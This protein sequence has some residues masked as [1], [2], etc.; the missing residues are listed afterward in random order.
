MKVQV[1]ACLGSWEHTFDIHVGDGNKTFKWLG[2]T[3]AERIAPRPGGRRRHRECSISPKLVNINARILPTRVSGEG[4]PFYHPD[5]LLCEELKDGAV[6]IITLSSTMSVDVRRAPERDRWMLIAFDTSEQMKE[7]RAAA[8]G[9]EI[10]AIEAIRKAEE[11]EHARRAAA[12]LR[13]RA[14]RMRPIMSSQIFSPDKVSRAFKED[15]NKCDFRGY[16]PLESLIEQPDER[17]QLHD[18]LFKHY[19][20]LSELFKSYSSVGSGVRT[21]DMDFMEFNVLIHDIKLFSS[22]SRDA[23]EKIFTEGTTINQDNT[24]TIELA[25]FF[26]CIV[27]VAVLKYQAPHYIDFNKYRIGTQDAAPVKAKAAVEAVTLLL[28]EYLMPVVKKK[29]VGLQV[30]QALETDALLALLGDHSSDLKLVFEK[31]GASIADS[32]HNMVDDELNVAEFGLILEEAR[33]LG[34]RGKDDEELTFKEARQAF[35]GAQSDL[36]GDGGGSRVAI[37]GGH[38]EQMSFAE[39]LEAIARVAL[40]KWDDPNTPLFDKVE[41]ALQSVAA[42]AGRQ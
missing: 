37:P 6:V 21:D 30:K 36:C 38:Q 18:L 9:E 15:W 31:Y 26:Y 33:L 14:E 20:P 19:L 16:E 42:L 35:S 11:E 25:Q 3:V 7:K 17:Q 28:E 34:G 32:A 22:K 41:W 4:V 5:K 24:S 29:L 1:K 40:L 27:K 12:L 8:W 39:F 23:V 2:L 10:R 13:Q